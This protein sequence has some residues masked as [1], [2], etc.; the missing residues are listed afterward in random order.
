MS[1]EGPPVDASAEL[2]DGRAFH[3]VDQLK[4][5]L[6]ADEQQLARALGLKLLLYAT[7]RPPST[8]DRAELDEIVVRLKDKHYGLRSL[9][10]EIVQS[11]ALRGQ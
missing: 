10:H 7:G 6:L 1:L 5:L 3:D 4:T 9:V 8:A 2:A 11:R